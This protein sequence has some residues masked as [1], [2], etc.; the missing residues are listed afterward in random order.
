MALDIWTM[1]WM[2]LAVFATLFFFG[3]LGLVYVIYRQMYRK[4]NP[5][6]FVIYDL[7]KSGTKS[8]RFEIGRKDFDKKLGVQ[9]VTAGGVSPSSIKESLGPN[10][11]DNDIYQRSNSSRKTCVLCVKD[12]IYTPVKLTDNPDSL[13]LS[14]IK[15]EAMSVVL[16]GQD[17]AKSLY[18]ANETGW[19]KFLAIAGIVIFTICIVGTIVWVIIIL[20]QAPKFLGDVNTMNSNKATGATTPPPS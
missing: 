16:Q 8:I 15:F 20:T 4:K 13:S 3:T 6:D 7:H 14:P 12:G 1:L 2:A 11:S 17:V 5:I 9:Y 18:E 10:I 19:Q